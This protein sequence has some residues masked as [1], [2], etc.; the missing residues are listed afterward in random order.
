MYEF[1]ENEQFE[2]AHEIKG[3]IKF[4]SMNKDIQTVELKSNENLDVISGTTH[5]NYM[6]FCIQFYRNGSLVNSDIYT[7]EITISIRDTIRQFINQF[8]Q[9]KQ[10]PKKLVTNLN[11]DSDDVFFE[12]DLIIPK[13]GK[14]SAILNLSLKNA[15]ENID[16]KILEY[17]HKQEM[18]SNGLD[19]LK[20]TI[21]K[22]NLNHIIMIDNSNTRNSNPVSV[23]V[24]Y[25]NGLPQKSEYRKFNITA[26]DRRGDVEYM[27]QGLTQYF[28][29]ENQIPDL[30]IVDGGIQ[31][32]NEARFALGKLNIDIPIVG[33]VKNNQH[34]TSF[35]LLENR[36]EKLINE[37]AY[38]FLSG[39]QEEV[40]R[41]AKTVHRN[42]NSKS[43]LES[44][45]ANIQG[46]GPKT[47]IK[48]LN[49][50]KTYNNIYNAT[51]EELQKVVSLS[52]AQEIMKVFK[53]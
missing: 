48:I 29:K 41:F 35:L 12:T 26:S 2:R 36:Q 50:F 11:L 10:L 44:V 38:S 39:I 27:N 52:V 3:V 16:F 31:Q 14:Y 42:K 40:D 45:L 22:E 7:V 53:N 47:E 43:S 37:K 18:V 32:L 24:S 15:K 23:I 13:Q 5:N 21:D 49:H 28:N 9:N 4:L 51:L 20:N 1:S 46:I 8:Y 17:K 25:R 19:F 6:V 33:L 34:K 30:L